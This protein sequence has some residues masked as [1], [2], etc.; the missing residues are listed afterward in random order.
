MLF[1]FN[2]LFS[3]YL[4]VFA[5]T[6]ETGA[7]LEVTGVPVVCDNDGTCDA[8][9]D[10]SNCPLDCPTVTP[11]GGG[12]GEADNTSPT[13]YNIAVKETTLKAVI[14]EWEVTE[15]A[16]CQLLW[17]KTQNYEEGI[18]IEKDF[19]PQKHSTSL[20]DLLPA[21]LYYFEIS[22]CDR[23]GNASARS[24]QFSTLT[25]P[26]F[27]PPANVSNFSAI[28]G[29]EQIELD[30]INPLRPGSGDFKG[31][32]IVRSAAFYPADPNS[33][34]PVYDGTGENFTDT[35]LENGVRYYYTAF[36]CDKAGNYSSGAIVSGVPHKPGVVPPPEEI[37]TSTIPI[38]P[39]IE[40]LNFDDFDFSQ[41][42]EKIIP[43]EGKFNIKSGFPLTASITYEKVPEVLKTIMVTLAQGEKI[44][45]FLLS[46][47]KEKT[48]YEAVIASPDPG[49]YPLTLNILDY[50]NQSL[51]TLKGELVIT[52]LKTAAKTTF[53]QK[54]SRYIYILL[55]VIILIIVHLIW[56]KTRERK[57]KRPVEFNGNYGN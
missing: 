16:L 35:G 7:S 18:A 27:T 36:A 28:A 26:D 46:I 55:T 3:N 44:F 23:S 53:C 32:K 2:L 6:S 57:N 15:Y 25:P 21:T 29:D 1:L 45:S 9:E 49:R 39:E 4:L 34:I 14:I 54:W 20:T 31:V 11:P 13:I 43:A 40:K 17:G 41:G 42:G 48:R 56:R 47:N 51:K 37:P 12:G 52:G 38:T 50:K 5:Q 24:S 8:G 30:W 22:C 33:G 10:E 19:T